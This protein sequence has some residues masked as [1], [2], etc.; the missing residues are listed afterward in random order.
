MT[1]QCNLIDYEFQEYVSSYKSSSDRGRWLLYAILLSCFFVFVA[2]WNIGD[3]SWPIAHLHR[4]K[5]LTLLKA[6]APSIPTESQRVPSTFARSAAAAWPLES[7][8]KREQIQ[9]LDDEVA[10]DIPYVARH[11]EYMRQFVGRMAVV[12]IPIVGVS[13]DVNDLG[14]ICGVWLCILMLLFAAAV[15]REYENLCLA[16]FKV[17]KLFEDEKRPN[18]GESKANLLYHALAMS[19]MLSHPPTLAR[20]R[21]RGR[22]VFGFVVIAV[23]FLPAALQA[24]VAVTNYGLRESSMGKLADLHINLQIILIIILVAAAAHATLY[25]LVMGI[26]WELTFF[27][28]NP[29]R[30]RQ[31]DRW[32]K[33]MRWDDLRE[34]MLGRLMTP[35]RAIG[36][37]PR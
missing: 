18:D 17:R 30:E 14:T 31:T 2:T 8:E 24:W 6:P 22:T 7:I 27:L 35:L 10:Q 12:T 4:W 1:G 3:R 25:S 21:A 34:R 23:F 15:A 33:Y 20:W 26:R 28:I 11:E 36:L 29:A 13:I 9:P 5:T 32:Q 37:A 16:F 19:Q